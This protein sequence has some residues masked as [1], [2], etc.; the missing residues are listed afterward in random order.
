ML[1][2]G[3]SQLTY[4]LWDVENDKLVIGRH[5]T[6]NENSILDAINVTPN[7]VEIF[8]SEAEDPEPVVQKT[9]ADKR[10]LNNNENNTEQSATLRRS[11]RERHR[12]DRYEA[13]LAE[14]FSLCTRVYSE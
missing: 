13:S 4:P 9:R 10:N 11:Q 2:Y 5:V 7:V 8:D 3:S 1:G 14:H 6:F 12:P